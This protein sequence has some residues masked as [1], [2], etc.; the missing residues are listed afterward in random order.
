MI[1]KNRIKRVEKYR[2]EEYCKKIVK[3]EENPLENYVVTIS[4]TTST[5]VIRKKV[6]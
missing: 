2:I 3:L 6:E 4:I 1:L 5:A